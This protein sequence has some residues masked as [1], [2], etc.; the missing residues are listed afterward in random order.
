VDGKERLDLVIDV[1]REVA[2]E[3]GCAF[4]D[5]RELMGGPD[6]FRS[7]QLK[8]MAQ[9]DGVHLTVTGYR[10]LGEMIAKQILES[11]DH[12]HPVSRKQKK[13]RAKRRPDERSGDGKTHRRGR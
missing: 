8:G 5:L 3:A 12:H 10:V 13:R 4:M 2:E 11:Y 9:P 6:S 7:W 1:Q